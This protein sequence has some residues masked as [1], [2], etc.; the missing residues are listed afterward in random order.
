M[1]EW[2]DNESGEDLWAHQFS[3]DDEVE[4]ADNIKK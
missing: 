2:L 1:L 3:I 4:E